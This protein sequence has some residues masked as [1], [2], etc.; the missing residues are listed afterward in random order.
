MLC[1]AMDA[2]A[3]WVWNSEDRLWTGVYSEHRKRWVHVDPCE[4]VFDRPKLY[5]E[6]WGK[7]MAYVIAFSTDGVTDVTR[8]YVRK[9]EH[10]AERDRCPEAVLLYVMNEIKSLRRQNMSEE[11]K[12][13]LEDED[14]REQREL[15]DFIVSSITADFMATGWANAE[16]SSQLPKSMRET[17][18][19]S[20]KQGS[21]GVE[22]GPLVIP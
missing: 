6:G 12:M 7:K 21:G 9:L 22:E 10:A 4:G 15:N 1:R 19:H 8:R 14:R 18:K 17:T 2:R 3:R 16:S 5:S 13:R 11:E 20:S